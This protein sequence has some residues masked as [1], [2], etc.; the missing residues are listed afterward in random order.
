VIFGS[1]SPVAVG[2]VISLTVWRTFIFAILST[3]GA[4]FTE[5]SLPEPDA[6]LTYA[7]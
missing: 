3:L 5:L 6:N 2:S 4:I 7:C 1:A